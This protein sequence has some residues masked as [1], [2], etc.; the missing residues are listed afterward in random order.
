MGFYTKPRGAVYNGY[1]GFDEADELTWL[2]KKSC[3]LCDADRISSVVDLVLSKRKS[4][5]SLNMTLKKLI[6]ELKQDLYI[7][8]GTYTV[9]TILCSH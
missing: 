6:D 1:A 2:L 4:V 8:F 7:S 3:P 5:L 9:T